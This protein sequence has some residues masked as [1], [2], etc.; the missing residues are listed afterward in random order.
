MLN[1]PPLRIGSFMQAVHSRSTFL[2]RTGGVATTLLI[3]SALLTGCVANTTTEPVSTSASTA[4]PAPVGAAP[5]EDEEPPQGV[6]VW[7]DPSRAQAVQLTGA[8]VSAFANHRRSQD[9]WWDDFSRY[10]TPRA[11]EAY[12]T[13]QVAN[14]PVSAVTGIPAIVDESSPY[15]AVLEV[16]TDIGAYRVQLSR[17]GTG[18]PWLVERITPAGQA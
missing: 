11:A 4:T 3:T 16:P 6:P 14:I 12:R 13:V 7:D 9:E 2:I 15:L 17:I 1:P 18:M 10:L 5:L 8:A